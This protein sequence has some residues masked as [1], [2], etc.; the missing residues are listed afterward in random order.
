MQLMSPSK[1]YCTL[2]I[3]LITFSCTENWGQLQKTSYTH[4]GS[5]VTPH[6]FFSGAIIKTIYMKIIF[7][8]V[9]QAWEGSCVRVVVWSHY[10]VGQML[11]LMSCTGVL[12][13]GF[14]QQQ[15]MLLAGFVIN[16]A[17][18]PVLEIIAT[19]C[20]CSD[21]W[22]QHLPLQCLQLFR[23]STLESWVGFLN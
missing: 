13:V 8:R 19:V 23:K 9:M 3:I 22:T 20:F 6:L 10:L 15:Q 5:G 2:A 4:T 11:L 14:N 17:V 1:F 16:S 18:S 12:L 7:K 21:L